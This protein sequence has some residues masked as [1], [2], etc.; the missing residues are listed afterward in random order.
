MDPALFAFS[1]LAVLLIVAI[2]LRRR[3]RRVAGAG[4]E[5]PVEE[6]DP[7]PQ[8]LDQEPP[9]EPEL[10]VASDRPHLTEA[11][12]AADV[13]ERAMDLADAQHAGLLASLRKLEEGFQVAAPDR[14]PLDLALAVISL[15]VRVLSDLFP[16]DRGSRLRRLMVTS[17]PEDRRE[18]ALDELIGYA[19]AFES[20][21]GYGENPVNGVG[22]RLLARWRGRDYNPPDLFADPLLVFQAAGQLMSMTG[23]WQEVTARAEVVR[24]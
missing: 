14:A 3:A 20:A 2:L 8:T 6:A 7:A 16:A 1:L 21:I 22:A 4:S 24:D 15:E 19:K 17:L 23:G 5:P 13:C 10:A 9:P 12:A 18:Y 11:A